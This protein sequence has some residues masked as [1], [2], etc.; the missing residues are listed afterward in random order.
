MCRV[1][2]EAYIHTVK[3]HLHLTEKMSRTEIFIVW[4]TGYDLFVTN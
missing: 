4:S 1:Y 2:V 3:E